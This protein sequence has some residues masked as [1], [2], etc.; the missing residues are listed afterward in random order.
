MSTDND[1]MY[2]KKFQ[3]RFWEKVVKQESDRACWIWIG[4]R[5]QDGYGEIRLNKKLKSAHIVSYQMKHGD[6]SIPTG[7]LIRHICNVKQCVNPKHLFLGTYQDNQ[8]DKLK[9]IPEWVIPI[10]PSTIEVTKE[11]K[12]RIRFLSRIDIKG[13][14]ECWLW[15]GTIHKGGYGELSINNKN[16]KTHRMSWEFFR[17]EIPPELEVCH[18]CDV[19][20]CCNPNHLWLG[21][22]K[23]NME[24]RRNKGNHREELNGEY[25]RGFTVHSREK[26]NSIFD[27]YES[28]M[29]RADIA[30][31]LN[32]SYS[33]IR[34]ILDGKVRRDTRNK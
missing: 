2:S 8:L 11:L 30:R 10:D 33:H 14:D 21:T 31:Q 20:H 27:M 16:L 18:T 15:Q 12:D 32:I 1:S 7:L 4:S 23:E 3:E 9:P 29:E 17:G 25:K 28:G 22:H 34:R 24:D 6:N 5:R 26:I 19:R 13:E